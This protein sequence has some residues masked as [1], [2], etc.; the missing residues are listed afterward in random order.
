MSGS[1]RRLGLRAASVA[2]VFGLVMI[3]LAP[4][5]AAAAP[6]ITS[7]SPVSGPAG[8]IVTINGTFDPL[9]T[10]ADGVTFHGVSAFSYTAT[11]NRITAVVPKGATTG[12]IAVKNADGTDDTTGDSPAN[13]TVTAL[14]AP[15]ITG[16]S[17]TCGAQGST[18]VISGT[19]L[20]GTDSVTFSSGK[21]AAFTIVSPSRLDT[22]VPSAPSPG[23][24]TGAIAV[25]TSSSAGGGGSV[26]T[27]TFSVSTTC[28]TITSFSP[29]LGGVGTIVTIAGTN[30]T[31]A[32]AVRFNNVSAS[33]LSVGSSTLI[34]ATVP[35]GASTGKI[36]VTTPSGTATSL[37]DFTVVAAPAITSFQP[38]SGPRGTVVTIL[39][40][41]FSG[42][43]YTTTA[44]TFNGV[45][46][47]FS[48][49][50]STQITATVPPTAT[51]GPIRVTTIGGTGASAASFVVTG[52]THAR[53][54]SLSRSGM[55]VSGTV[56]VPDGF[57]ACRVYVPV[58][59]QRRGPQGGW[60]LVELLSANRSGNF[61]G[62]VPDA[63][64]QYRAKAIRVEVGSGDVCAAASSRARG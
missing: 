30:L 39:G 50:T 56:N 2:S 55:R 7:F 25:V 33:S 43:G 27:P 23:A 26:N 24:V 32:T 16:I 12:L 40:S 21:S 35:T 38:T 11:T 59:I 49:S 53:S 4:T 15:T 58:A 10:A 64:V 47:S 5:A 45:A 48:V 1:R 22:V 51:T 20:I 8:T 63:S 41:N 29:T 61:G 44:V 62:F 9:P 52:I 34:T 46:A 54:V 13:F 18:V 36:S 57:S 42:F 3:G 37:A 31:G 17:P 60:R 6:T 19:G 14:P 28:P